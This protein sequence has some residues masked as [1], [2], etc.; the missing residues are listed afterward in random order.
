MIGLGIHFVREARP[1]LG[2]PVKWRPGEFRGRI[3]GRRLRLGRAFE[4][5]RHDNILLFNE[6]TGGTDAR[7]ATAGKNAAKRLLSA[8][9]AKIRSGHVTYDATTDWSAV[10]EA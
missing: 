9:R 5:C 6:A 2:L 3:P 1:G 4:Q 7:S 10:G 8:M